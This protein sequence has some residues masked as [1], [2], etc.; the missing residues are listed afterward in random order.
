MNSASF[1]VTLLDFDVPAMVGIISPVRCS[2]WP[3]RAPLAPA[4]STVAASPPS[5]P[6]C[7]RTTS[8]GTTGST[9]TC[10]ASGR[11][12]STSSPGTPTAPTS[13][14]RSTPSSCEIFA[15]NSL[16]HPG[17]LE[18]ARLARRP[19][20]GHLRHLRDRR[21]HRPPH[22]LGGLLPRHPALHRPDHLRALPH[23]PH[24]DDGQPAGQSR[25]RTT[26]SAPTP[27]P[28]PEEW[29]AQRSAGRAAGGITGRSGS[30]PA[31]GRSALHRRS[32]QPRHKPLDPAPGRYVREG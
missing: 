30:S 27:G 31:P 18:R 6:G 12:P 1:G 13:R 3:G 10:S 7:G 20:P 19:R 2:P 5:S 23:R 25:S 11:P 14:R 28:D 32:W 29:R 22:P 16:V 15:Q 21:A 26:S 9:T 4:S 8:S 17:A 24:P